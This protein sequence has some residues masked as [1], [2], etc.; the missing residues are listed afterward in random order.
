MNA[1]V[2]DFA[3]EC[4]KISGLTWM[5]HDRASYEALVALINHVVDA[6]ADKAAQ[7]PSDVPAI[8]LGVIHSRRVLL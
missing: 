2:D 6:C 3:R 4:A 1:K 5:I 8:I 7:N